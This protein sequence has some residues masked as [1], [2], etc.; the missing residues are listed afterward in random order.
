METSIEKIKQYCKYCNNRKFDTQKGIICSITGFKPDFDAVCPNYDEDTY[1]K[2]NDLNSEDA[3]PQVMVNTAGK[4]IRLLNYLIDRVVVILFMLVVLIFIGIIDPGVIDAISN[5]GRLGD[6][7]LSLLFT[8]GYYIT[9][10]GVWGRSIGKMI[11]NTR[12]VDRNGNQPSFDVIL[13][14]SFCRAI[15]FDAFSFLGEEGWHDSFSK[16]YVVHNKSK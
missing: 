10:E 12:V 5:M 6:L 11:T 7:L 13:T 15:P 2:N 3:V 4:G 14:R 9:F 1:L 8:I 16:T